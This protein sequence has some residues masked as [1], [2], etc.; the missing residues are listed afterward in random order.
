LQFGGWWYRPPPADLHLAIHSVVEEFESM[1]R[2][3][4]G[5]LTVAFS[6]AVVVGCNSSSTS[7]KPTAQGTNINNSPDKAKKVQ[8]ES[9]GPD[10]IKP[11]P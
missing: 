6:L 9:G 3:L 1:K 10:A 4:I 5:I 7:S 8:V 2:K 11:P